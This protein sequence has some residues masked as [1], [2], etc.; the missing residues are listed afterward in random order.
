MSEIGKIDPKCW[1]C[2]TLV[3][4]TAVIYSPL[5]CKDCKDQLIRPLET[6]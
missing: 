3:I 2:G 4:P 1:C 6:I 5:R